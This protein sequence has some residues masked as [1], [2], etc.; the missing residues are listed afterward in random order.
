MSPSQGKLLH[1][2]ARIAGGRTILEIGTLGGY[3]TIWLSRALPDDGTIVTLEADPHHADVARAN[4][5]RANVASRVDVRLGPALDTL[6]VLE[7]ERRAP[8]D[9]VFI[10]A[11]KRSSAAYF[12]WA[13]RL[14]RPGA[15][16]VADN[17]VRAGAVVDATSRD[18]SVLGV[19]AL[20]ARLAQEP[21]VVATALQTVGSKGWD[22]FI[23]ARVVD[24]APGATRQN[25]K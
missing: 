7:A 5:A 19:R 20:A 14:A 15:T 18:Q 12:D 22:V 23:L 13:L 24:A 10:D 17:V 9:L 2:L 16:I 1:L 4:L 6:P 25:R 11:D 3:S 21:R 8:F